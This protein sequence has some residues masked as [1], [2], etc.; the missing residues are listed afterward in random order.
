MDV[1]VDGRLRT[2]VDTHAPSRSAQQSVFTA[3]LPDGH[4]TLRPVRKSGPYLVVD[5]F[6][7]R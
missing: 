3:D 2:T 6:T 5:R 4:H 1:Y 7:I